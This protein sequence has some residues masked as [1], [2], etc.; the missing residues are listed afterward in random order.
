MTEEFFRKKTIGGH[1]QIETS[2]LSVCDCCARAITITR[3]FLSVSK[4]NNCFD[5]KLRIENAIVLNNIKFH[6]FV[7]SY[8][9]FPIGISSAWSVKCIHEG[10]EKK[11]KNA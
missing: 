5:Q 11:K 10:G 3:P 2:C 9:K 4:I 1:I 6:D 8:T 7:I